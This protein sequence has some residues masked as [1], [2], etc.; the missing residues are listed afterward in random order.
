[1]GIVETNTHAVVL[2]GG[3]TLRFVV[4]TSASEA[5]PDTLPTFEVSG[6][7]GARVALRRGFV[8]PTGANVHVA[9]VEAPSDRWAPGMEEV[10]LGVANGVMHR[11]MSQRLAIESLD[12]GSIVSKDEHF[13]QQLSGRARRE[14]APVKLQGRHSLGFEGAKKEVV[15]CSVI[16][17]EAREKDQCATIVAGATLEGLVAAPPPSLLVQGVFFAAEKPA[18]A[19][20]IVGAVGVL[21]VGLILAKRPRP[22]P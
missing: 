9:C 18:N 5:A 15:L 13:D 6:L 12:A 19:A 20:A 17:D 8:D 10:V 2:Q 7:P 21:V 4:P 1:M 11:A 16:C 14:Q 22:K 3:A